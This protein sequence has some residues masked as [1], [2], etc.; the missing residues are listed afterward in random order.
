MP[1]IGGGQAQQIY[2]LLRVPRRALG[3][4][5]S[6]GFGLLTLLRLR[7][8]GLDGHQHS[9]AQGGGDGLGQ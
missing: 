7:W 1:A 8:R 4:A 2:L 6:F 9:P 5:L 3:I